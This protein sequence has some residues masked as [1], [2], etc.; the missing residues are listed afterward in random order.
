MGIKMSQKIHW[1]YL[2]AMLSM[3]KQKFIDQLSCKISEIMKKQLKWPTGGHFGFYTRKSCHG[4]SLC[5]TLVCS[6]PRR[7]LLNY[8]IIF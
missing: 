8:S 4:L 5:E 7:R 3:I 2:M 1:C 6:P